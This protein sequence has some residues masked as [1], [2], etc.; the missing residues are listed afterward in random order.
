MVETCPFSETSRCRGWD[1]T[2]SLDLRDRDDTE[3]LKNSDSRPRH[4][5]RLY[6]S[7]FYSTDFVLRVIFG[8]ATWTLGWPLFWKVWKVVLSASEV[9]PFTEKKHY[10][11]LLTFWL[12]FRGGKSRLKYFHSV[13]MQA[14]G[15]QLVEEHYY[16]SDAK[17]QRCIKVVGRAYSL[18][19]FFDTVDA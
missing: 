15:L 13:S 19:S 6:S 18:T 1:E 7:G 11:K 8:G 4:V 9:G 10:V 12:M 2:E 5:L 17:L 16:D 14:I 3:T